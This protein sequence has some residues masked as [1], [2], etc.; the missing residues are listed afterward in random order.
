[1]QTSKAVEDFKLVLLLGSFLGV[2][3]GGS[4]IMFWP[5]PYCQ[6]MAEEPSGIYLSDT[7]P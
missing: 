6:V 7:V 5:P 2:V 4:F 1:M 3:I